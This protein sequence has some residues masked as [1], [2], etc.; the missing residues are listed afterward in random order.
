MGASQKN[1]QLCESLLAL[2]CDLHN[3]SFFFAH[4]IYLVSRAVSNTSHALSLSISMCLMTEGR[5]EGCLRWKQ[6]KERMFGVWGPW[7]V[8]RQR[9]ER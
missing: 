3:G 9:E 1:A 4:S 5:R 2:G 8:C 6:G 7:D